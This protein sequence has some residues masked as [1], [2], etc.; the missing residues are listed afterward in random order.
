MNFSRNVLIYHRISSLVPDEPIGK[1]VT[2]PECNEAGTALVPKHGEIVEQKEAA[3]GKVW[4]NCRN[5][6]ERFLVYY[7]R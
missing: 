1:R 3:I 7:T 6:G 2:C 4:T 5:C